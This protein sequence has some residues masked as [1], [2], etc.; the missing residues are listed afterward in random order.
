MK[1][2]KLLIFVPGYN[3]E[4]TIGKVLS[5][6][7]HLQKKLFFDVLYI[8]NNSSDQS[9]K[10]ARTFVAKKRDITFAVVQ[11]KKNLGY[12]GSQ[13]KAF[14]YAFKNKYDY[15]IEYAADAQY[16]HKKINS[17]Y[18]KS[19]SG[20]YAIVFGS[21]VT[22][23]HDIIEMPKWKAIGNKFFNRLNNWAFK[24]QVSEIHTGFRVY[25]L[26]FIKG[27]AIE[28][29]HDDYRWT[30]DS[31]IEIRKVN[32]S[33]GEIAVKALYHKDAKSPNLIQLYQ[34]MSYM[35]FRALKYKLLGI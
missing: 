4:N 29:C 5:N 8:D 17:L 7:Q 34:V 22:H 33:F 15:L 25:N 35:F 14:H 6:L 28:K 1:K 10:I 24:F 12:G 18:K 27:F 11:N 26:N 21:R 20:K 3:V 16:P 19:L 31:V 32:S 30:M 2:A 13:K 23:P 9:V